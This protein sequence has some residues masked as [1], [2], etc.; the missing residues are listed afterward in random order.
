MSIFKHLDAISSR[1]LDVT[2]SQR[3]RILPRTE[4]SNPNTRRGLDTAREVI[5]VDC[6][7]E[8]NSIEFGME[9]GVRKSYREANDLRNVSVGR[10]ALVSIDRRYFP[11]QNKEP[12]QGDLLYMLKD[13]G[14]LDPNYPPFELMDNQRDGQARFESRLIQKD[15][16][17]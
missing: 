8:Y 12:R 4:N 7:F 2:N 5:E 10:T 14:N 9:L 6:I 13:D 11:D 17:T 16:Q 15:S 1:V 3:C